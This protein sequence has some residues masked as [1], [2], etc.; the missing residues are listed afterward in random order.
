MQKNF[1]TA[2]KRAISKWHHYLDVYERHFAPYRD[3]EF[4]L[5]EIGV[6]DGG[7]LELWRRYFDPKAT[8]VG[9][10]LKPTCA[11]HVDP[12]NHVRIGPQEDPDFLKKVIEEFGRP[13][14]IL[15]D[16]SHFSDHQLASF[17]ILFP[18]LKQGGLYAIEDVHTSYWPVYGGGYKH[19]GTV[20]EL[21]KRIIDDMHAW[22]HNRPTKTLARDEIPGVHIYDS[23]VVFE[24]RTKQRPGF[25]GSTD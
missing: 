4:F 13:D 23:V 11:T 6:D 24:K 1:F 9:I 7:S 14:I 5:L 12:E 17:S 21:T 20:I 2:G 16:G 3:K 25:L 22:Y 8:I 19:K 10:D 18:Y 15:D